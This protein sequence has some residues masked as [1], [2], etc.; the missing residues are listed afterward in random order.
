MGPIDRSDNHQPPLD[1]LLSQCG[2]LHLPT[3]HRLQV[4]NHVR[5]LGMP[6]DHRGEFGSFVFN[7]VAF[8]PTI[9]SHESPVLYIAATRVRSVRLGY[10]EK[11]PRSTSKRRVRR[12]VIA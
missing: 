5:E 4:P 2:V 12:S 10:P 6:V 8:Q 11:Q 3:Q 1:L 7:R 9:I